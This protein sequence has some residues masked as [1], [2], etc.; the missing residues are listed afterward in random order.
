MGVN[1]DKRYS[2]ETADGIVAV[3]FIQKPEAVDI[4]NAIDDAVEINPS[5][6]MVWDLTCGAN[7][8]DDAIQSIV[9]HASTLQ[10]PAGKAAIVAPQDL[11]YGLSRVYAA[12]RVENQVKLSVFRSEPEAREWLKE[13]P[14]D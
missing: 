13:E 2:I 11:T 14:E 7:L 1:M 4:C 6:L 5:N 10:L 9:H 8:P 3:R 12:H